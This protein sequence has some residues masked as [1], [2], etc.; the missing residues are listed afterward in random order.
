MQFFLNGYRSGDPAV[1]DAA[2][3]REAQR[4]ADSLPERV[5]V[6]IVGSGPTGL[7]LA[8]QLASFPGITTRIVDQRPG[9]LQIGQADGISCR[10]MEMFEAF[11]F[12][13]RV[14][15]EAY[16][17]NE[18]C[19]WSPDDGRR[20]HIVRSRV[21]QDVEDGLSEFPHVILN[22]ARI[23]EFLLERM[24]NAPAPLEPDYS[25]RLI[26]LTTD[27]SHAP[28]PDAYPHTLRFERLA[29]RSAG[30]VE[31]VHAKYVVGCDGARSAVRGFLGLTLDGSSS[32]QTWGVMD[33]LAITSFPDIRRKAAIHSADQG[34]MIIIPREG[35][36]LVRLYIELSRLAA[37]QR[38]PDLDVTIDTLIGAARRILQPYTLEVREVAWWSVYEIG[39][40]LCKRFDDLADDPT[41]AAAKPFPRRFIAGDA[42]HTHSPKAGQGMN[43]SM[44]DG[45]NLGWKLASVL[46]GRAWPSL[47]RTY[48]DERCAVARDLIEFDHQIARMLSARPHRPGAV[49][50]D[51]VDP[52]EFQA[53]FQRRGRF[54]AGT[55]T[56]YGSSAIIGDAAHQDL[57][58]GFK[59]GMRFHSAAVV[60]LAD[61]KPVH[62]GHV[63]R[64]DGRWRLLAFADADRPAA[65][66]SRL[67]A[68]CDFLERSSDSPLLRYTPPGEDIDSVIETIAICQQA[69]AELSVDELPAILL[70]HKGRYGLI[71]YEKVYCPDFKGG[72]DIFDSRVIDRRHGALV[73]VRPDQHIAGV[74][75]LI[76]YEDLARFFAGFMVPA[77]PEQAGDA[78]PATK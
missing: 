76:A 5:D 28:D 35:G 14:L 66:S 61:A 36:Y 42:C 56:Q 21:I 47:L 55:A 23:H 60:R 43:V 53:F 27:A 16:W 59:I 39:Q 8:A 20:G 40:R 15:R 31:T 75:P 67:R 72:A 9:P 10:S 54:M 71:D 38:V 49:N 22:Q 51:T 45:F 26:E 64:A 24:R 11:G 29:G 74:L 62:L 3:S 6:M 58:A 25:L 68:L 78:A 50:E 17:V 12:S 69:H 7:T 57:A 18:T 44:Q 73:I 32:R 34:S 37:N 13:E 63:V 70:P 77:G 4:L 48:S 33:V 2:R 30:S 19:F 1:S 65:G 52:E 46:L 41:E